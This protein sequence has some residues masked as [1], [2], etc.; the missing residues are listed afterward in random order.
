MGS[1]REKDKSRSLGSPRATGQKP[2][3]SSALPPAGADMACVLQV[4]RERPRLL[5]SDLV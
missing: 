5:L 3:H 1:L 2:R 4:R